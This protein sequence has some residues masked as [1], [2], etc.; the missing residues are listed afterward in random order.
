MGFLI[1]KYTQE[2]D[3]VTAHVQLSSCWVGGSQDENSELKT[4]LENIASSKLTQSTQWNLGYSVF[5]T[6][7]QNNIQNTHA[8]VNTI[9]LLLEMNIILLI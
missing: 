2:L 6:S 8:R 4:N 1:E 7:Q 5:Q 9:I 3:M